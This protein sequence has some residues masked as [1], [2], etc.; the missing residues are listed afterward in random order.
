M[1]PM[2]L[3]QRLLTDQQVEDGRKGIGITA[4]P[5]GQLV[6]PLELPCELRLKH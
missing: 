2:L 1:V 6:I 4:T 3:R 5:Q